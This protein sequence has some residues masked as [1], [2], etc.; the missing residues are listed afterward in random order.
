MS[1]PHSSMRA[2]RS[3]AMVPSMRE[4]SS[5]P[6]LRP[7]KA[8]ASGTTTWAWMSMVRMRRPPTM[9]CALLGR[10]GGLGVQTFVHEVTAGENDSGGGRCFFM[11]CLRLVMV[12]PSPC[13]V[14]VAVFWGNVR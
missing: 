6:V 10:G 8:V 12:N 7:S 9:T 11:N 3:V 13:S 2:K 1:V 4:A 5:A 14:S